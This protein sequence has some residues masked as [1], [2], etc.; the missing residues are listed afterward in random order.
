MQKT[1][2]YFQNRKHYIITSTNEIDT[3]YTFLPSV[4]QMWKKKI[5]NCTFVLGFVSDRTE[6]DKF[7]QRIKSFCD[8]FYLFPRIPEIETGV[9]AK[10]TRLYLST[11]YNDE[12]CTFVDIDQY[13][14]NFDWF[15]NKIKDAFEDNKF[16]AIGANGYEYTDDTGKWPMPYNTAPSSVFKNIVNY[17]NI[18][19][20]VSWFNS[21]KIIENPI[22][23]KESV[24]NPFSKFSDE[25][26][27][28][29]IMIKHPDQ[30]FINKVWLK[31]DREDYFKMVA[32]RRIDRGWWEQS[33]NKENLYNHFY[34]DSF[35]LRPFNKFSNY[36]IPIL[37]YL[38]LDLST[39]KIFF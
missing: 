27:L 26:L 1:V 23:N 8:E 24:M 11:L 20:Y 37:E 14:L 30:D 15:F 39:D 7:T 4:Y 19:N 12:I 29:Y 9:Q 13:L 36:L 3:Y 25:S 10:T 35:P 16:V 31:K 32:S 18:D 34:I 2:D 6:D 22:D 38:N 21:Y 28:R 33:Y 17:N 5:P